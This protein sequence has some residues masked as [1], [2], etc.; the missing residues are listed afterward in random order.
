[1]AASPALVQSITAD[2]TT[3]VTSDCPMKIS[4]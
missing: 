3:S 2:A 1:M 4:P